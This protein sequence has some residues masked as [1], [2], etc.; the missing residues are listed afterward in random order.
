MVSIQLNQTYRID[1]DKYQWILVENDRNIGFFV[2]LED[3]FN[4]LFRRKLRLSNAKR[5]DDI[6][7]YLKTLDKWAQQLSTQLKSQQE[8]ENDTTN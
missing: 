4:A 3:L 7:Q 6:A 1:S 2:K 8:R 5:I